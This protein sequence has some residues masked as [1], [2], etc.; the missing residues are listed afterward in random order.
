MV[1]EL[2]EF[3]TDTNLALKTQKKFKQVS[4]SYLL[5][6]LSAEKKLQYFHEIFL[7]FSVCAGQCRSIQSQTP[8]RLLETRYGP[9][10]TGLRLVAVQAS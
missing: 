5:P 3:S 9:A 4:D 8:E 1:V 10:Y 7:F 2:F 6:V